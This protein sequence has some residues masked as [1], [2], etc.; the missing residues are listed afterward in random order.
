MKTEKSDLKLGLRLHA[1]LKMKMTPN[2]KM[3]RIK[4]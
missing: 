3:Q 1:I 2:R 4:L